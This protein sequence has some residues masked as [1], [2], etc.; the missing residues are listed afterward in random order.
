MKQLISILKFMKSV[1]T[2][3]QT[4]KRKYDKLTEEIGANICA[5]KKWD[6]TDKFFEQLQWFIHTYKGGYFELAQLLC[7]KY[8]LDKDSNVKYFATCIYN[9]RIGSL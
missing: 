3:K 5:Q 9:F 2:I 8:Q 6:Q 1:F 7:D 4:K